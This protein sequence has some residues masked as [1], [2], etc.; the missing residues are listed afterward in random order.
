MDLISENPPINLS[1]KSFRIYSRNSARP[2]QFIGANAVVENS[3]ISEG[4]RIYG[5]VENSILSGGVIV[6]E[7]AEVYNS[8]IME[9]VRICSGARIYTAIIDSDTVVG[10]DCVVGKIGADKNDITVIA[11]GTS[12]ISD[13]P[14]KA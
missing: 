1:D 8:V 13:I 14:P 12:V 5:K 2:P 10:K 3:M 7:D 4:C 9:D 6:E 11:K